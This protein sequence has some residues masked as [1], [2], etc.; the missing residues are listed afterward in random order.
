MSTS[1]LTGDCP[2]AIGPHQCNA[3]GVCA[4]CG[5]KVASAAPRYLGH[6]SAYASRYGTQDPRW[7]DGPDEEDYLDGR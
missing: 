6:P 5:A 4:F 1:T 2:E 7:I 3:R